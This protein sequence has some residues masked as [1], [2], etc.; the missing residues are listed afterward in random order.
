MRARLAARLTNRRALL[1]IVLAAVGAR[2][3]VALLMGNAVDTLPGVYDQVSYHTLAMRLVG[4]H[5][6]TFDRDWWPITRAGQPTAHWS[7]LYTLWLAAVYAV[8]G[9]QP[10]GARLLQ[11]VA[12]GALLPLFTYRITRRVFPAPAGQLEVT[13]LIASAWAALYGYLVYYAG[14]LMTES[15]YIVGLLWVLDVT[16]RLAPAGDGAPAPRRRWVELGL[17]LG[18]TAMLR[19]VFLPGVPVLLAWLYWR[20]LV[21]APQP[22]R[23]AA[24]G[25]LV[26]GTALAGAVCLALIAPITAFNY[27]QFHRLVLLNTNAGY[28]FFWANHPIYGDQFVAVLK[29]VE[30]TDLI[31]P[32][33]RRLDEAALDNALLQRGLQFVAADPARYLRLSLSRIPIYFMFWPTADSSWLSNAVRV[34]SF[35]VALPFMLL[36]LG[37]WAAAGRARRGP[38]LLLILFMAAYTAIHLLSW[39]LIRYRLPVDA[40]ALA[41]AARGLGALLE[42]RPGRLGQRLTNGTDAR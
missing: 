30:Y 27:R 7:Y 40:I 37:V 16:L 19:Q 14:A 9:A 13:A 32:E 20:R 2:V 31:P 28:A 38:G 10:L 18:L 17:A 35:G 11:A 29:D 23:A 24:A 15:M 42:R 41:F 3:A 22:A 25:R 33:L 8:V 1:A 5:G 6:F 21:R 4:G 12:A 26:V 36:G 39:A 34:L